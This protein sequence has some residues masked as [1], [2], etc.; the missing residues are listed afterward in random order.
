MRRIKKIFTKL[1]IAIIATVFIMPVAIGAASNVPMT[2]I[3]DYGDWMTPENMVGFNTALTDDM[4]EFQSDLQS[5]QL[6]ADYVP[7]E[8]KIGIALMNGLSLVADVLDSS[9]IRFAIIFMIL[10]Y[11]FWIMFEAYNMMAKGSSAMDLGVNLVKRGAVLAI[12]IIILV[13]GP[14]QIFMWVMGPII[15]VGTYL[16]DLILNA[17]ANTVGAELPNTC[18]AIHTYAAEHISEN[19][20]LDANT[21]AD[22]LC[23]PTRLSGFFI[24]AVAAGWKWMIAG[25]GHSAF[26]TLVGATF[27]ILFIYN[28]FKFALMAFGV[29][30]DLFLGVFMLPFTAIAETINKTSY[31]GIIG[32]IFNG[33]LG[34]FNPESLQRQITRFIDAAIYFVSLSIVIAL[35]TALLSGTIDANLA[36]EIPSIENSGFIITL[37]T[38]LLVAYLANRADSIAKDLGGKIDDSFGK[39]FGEDIKKL[40]NN[41]TN[42]GKNA[43]KIIR[44]KK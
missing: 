36:T 23:V 21:A 24:T 42:W 40:F 20:I 43:I 22:L 29:I 18:A 7:I 39:K 33:F 35:C 14:A 8:A 34:L 17:I 15:S 37:L 31:K 27:I 44:G 11:V 41:T 12:W 38:G 9:L 6:V 5:K 10:A 3:G 32:D 2:E 28:A 13:Q 26:T 25:I 19:M 4:N 16:S 1:I 30:V